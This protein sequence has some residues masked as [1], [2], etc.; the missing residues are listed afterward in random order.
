ML[1][2]VSTVPRTDVVWLPLPTHSSGMGY[3][4]RSADE[5]EQVLL[6]L[7]RSVVCVNQVF[8]LKT[9]AG[10]HVPR[11]V[12]RNLLARGIIHRIRHGAYVERIVWE[13]A[14]HDPTLMRQ[15]IVSAAMVGLREPA[16]AY[17]QIAAELHDLPIEGSGPSVL[18]LVRPHGHDLRSATSRVQERNRLEDV[19]ILGRDLA[20]ERVI[21][22][23]GIPSISMA[24]AALTAAA[25]FRR[26]Y[27]VGVFDSALAH[28]VSTA[29]LLDVVPRWAS[30]K[31][32]IRASRLIER[33]RPGAESIL[34]SI[35]RIRLMDGGLPEPVL[36]HEF[37]DSR[38][39]VG[40]VDMWWPEF[41]VVGEAD[42]LGKYNDVSD[43]RAEKVR[44]DRLRSLGLE[45]V[46]W[47]W[48]EIW[49][50][51][52]QVVARIEQASRRSA[53]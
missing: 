37:R 48:E 23:C 51:P 53:A 25:Q 19:R 1:R 49:S 17:G 13:T 7:R 45:V 24:S 36:Q 10:F 22:L 20:G 12:V 3:R 40:R 43:L 38:G 9:R 46:R 41:N 31:G 14:Q 35:S 44:E 29:E 21:E 52:R 34:E 8:S 4:R 2:S 28:G 30:G 42:G 5:L 15:L 6:D 33:A 18:E 32:V 11:A 47:T 39:F 50:S 27:A 26:E 16:Y